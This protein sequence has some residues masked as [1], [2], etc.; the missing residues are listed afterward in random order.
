[1]RKKLAQSS[2]IRKRH[3]V[4]FC[5]YCSWLVYR[6]KLHRILHPRL[7]LQTL[8]GQRRRPMLIQLGA[9]L[10]YCSWL[11]IYHQYY[12]QN[13]FKNVFLVPHICCSQQKVDI[14]QPLPMVAAP[15]RKNFASEGKLRNIQDNKIKENIFKFTS[16]IQF[17]RQ[18]VLLWTK[19]NRII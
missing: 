5:G 11:F 16:K 6:R 18:K 8:S 9:F 12:Q 1:M 10:R 14:R 3:L 17:L 15:R 7:L 2:N 4:A 19:R 13:A